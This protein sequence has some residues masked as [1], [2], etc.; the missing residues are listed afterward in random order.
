KVCGI[1]PLV[2]TLDD[3]ETLTKAAQ[4]AD[5]VIHAAS[6]DHADCVATL[7]TAL[8]RSGRLLIHTT[9]SV[10]VAVHAD[11]EYAGAAPL[12]EDDYFDPV[13]FGANRPVRE[14]GR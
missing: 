11:R 10:I 7:V 1:D 3:P 5:A 9:G 2:G 13:Q 4:A 6:A 12:M 14:F 8:Q